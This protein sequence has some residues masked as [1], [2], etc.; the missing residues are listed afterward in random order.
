MNLGTTLWVAEHV[1][2]YYKR[3][4]FYKIFYGY[5]EVTIFNKLSRYKQK[6]MSSF[7]PAISI[8]SHSVF[9]YFNG[10]IVSSTELSTSEKHGQQELGQLIGTESRGTPR[11][12]QSAKGSGLLIFRYNGGTSYQ[13]PRHFTITGGKAYVIGYTRVR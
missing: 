12:L 4:W 10:K 9:F 11:I 13:S 8:L 7:S 5:A 6:R 1:L 2:Q 3:Y